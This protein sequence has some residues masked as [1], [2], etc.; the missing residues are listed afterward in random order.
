MNQLEARI[1]GPENQ[2]KVR[3]GRRSGRPR[4]SEVAMRIIIPLVMVGSAA[5]GWGGWKLLFEQ[6]AIEDPYTPR[7]TPSITPTPEDTAT[8][9]LTPTPTRTPTAT[10]TPTI[11]PTLRPTEEPGPTVITEF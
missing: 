5:A 8:A 11:T 10:V 2:V 9:T 1:G 3:V 6:P 4:T 7:P